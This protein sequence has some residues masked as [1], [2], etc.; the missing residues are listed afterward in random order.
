MSLNIDATNFITVV[1]PTYNRYEK[2][3]KLINYYKNSRIKFSIIILDSSII[4]KEEIIRMQLDTFDNFSYL[5]FDSNIFF[6]DKI[7]RGLELVKTQ[8]VVLNADDDFLVPNTIIK[9]AEFLNN[10]EEYSICQGMFVSF[11]EKD[12]SENGFFYDCYL[13]MK[14]IEFDNPIDRFTYFLNNYFPVFYGVYRIELLM[15]IFR[16][17]KLFTDDTRFS[18]LLPAMLTSINGKIKILDDLFVALEESIN[19]DNATTDNMKEFKRKGLLNQKVARFRFCILEEF[20]LIKEPVN[21]LLEGIID[22]SIEEHL[23]KKIP[24]FSH[25]IFYQLSR[26]Y[27]SVISIFCSKKNHFIK[28]RFECSDDK[29]LMEIKKYILLNAN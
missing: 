9:S 21:I 3:I 24:S 17:N 4:K 7:A 1:I 22:S 25:R 23:A 27:I 6:A 19:S 29:Y 18:E 13:N 8:F 16:K 2:L 5:L 15:D 28:S 11:K 12:Y 20:K 14:S 26:F 10:N